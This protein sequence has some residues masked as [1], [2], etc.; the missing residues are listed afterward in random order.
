MCPVSVWGHGGPEHVSGQSEAI[1]GQSEP[2]FHSAEPARAL[3][4]KCKIGRNDPKLWP[5]IDFCILRTFY[6]AVDAPFAR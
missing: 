4:R 1:K 2:F 3:V 6:A 5:V